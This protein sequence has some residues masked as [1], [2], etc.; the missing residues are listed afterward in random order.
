M[1]PN[2]EVPD[3]KVP[4]LKEAAKEF[5]KA[6]TAI[7]EGLKKLLRPK[8]SDILTEIANRLGEMSAHLNAG[9]LLAAVRVPIVGAKAGA[10]AMGRSRS[11]IKLAALAGARATLAKKRRI[12]TEESMVKGRVTPNAKS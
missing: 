7:K 8:G 11:E 12:A 5:D 4:D 10:S 2:D 9:R 6:N 1:N 3:P